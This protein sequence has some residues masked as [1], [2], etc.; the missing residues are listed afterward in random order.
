MRNGERVMKNMKYTMLF[1]IALVVMMFAAC[2]DIFDKPEVKAQIENGYGRISI[3][4]TGEFT[5]PGVERTI[6]PSTTFDKYEYTFTKTGTTN[7]ITKV[8][9]NGYFILEAGSYTVEVKASIL[10]GPAPTYT[11]VA[12]GKSAQFSVSSNTST[13][14]QVPLSSTSSG[15]GK[16][17][18]A[19]TYP[20]GATCNITLKKW[21]DNS[22]INLTLYNGSGNTQTLPL[23]LDTGS[24]LLTVIIIGT[25]GKRAGKT[26]AV[27]IY[28]SLE[29]KY[30][31]DFTNADLLVAIPPTVNAKTIE[32]QQGIWENGVI[33]ATTTEQW[34]KFTATA[35]TQYIHVSFGTVTNLTVQLYDAGGKTV[36]NS[37]NL[38]SGGT[39][40]ISSPVA[41]DQVYYIKV[42]SSGNNG[43]YWI[44][45]SQNSTAPTSNFELTENIWTDG[46][47][48]S[49]RGEQWFKLTAT[50]NSY[51]YVTFGTLDPSYGVNIQLY[52]LSG[53]TVGSQETLNNSKT[54]L[55]VTSSQTYYIR[56]WPYNSSYTG[57][58][59]ITFNM[60]G[61][62]PSPTLPSNISSATTLYNY[63]WKDSAVS[64]T[65]EQW[66]KF[67]ATSSSQYIHVTFG[68]LNPLNGL[69]VQVYNSSGGTVGS[70]TNLRSGGSKSTYLSSVTSGQPYYVLVWPYNSSDTGT[71]QIAFNDSTTSPFPPS[72]SITTELTDNKWANGNIITSGDEQWFKLYKNN[73]TQYIH[74]S[75]GTLSSSIGLNVQVYD[76]SGNTVISQTRLS[77]S[78]DTYVYMSSSN[79]YYYYIKVTPYNSSG[80]GTYKIAFNS[81]ETAPVVLPSNATTLTANTWADGTVYSTGEQWFKFTAPSYYTYI[82]ASF[83]T[84]SSSYG[85]YVEVYDSSGST[86]IDQTNFIYNSSDNGTYYIYTSSL[87]SGQVY[88]I[89]ITPNDYGYTGTYQIAFNTSGNPPLPSNA[90]QGTTLT[91]NTWTEGNITSSN[92][93][94]FKLTPTSNDTYVHVNFGSLNSSNGLYVQLY[95]S[96]GSTSGYNEIYNYQKYVGLSLTSGQTYYIKVTPRYSGS[97]GTYQ[98]TFNTSY[99]PP[100]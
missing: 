64:S 97:T 53:S 80:T 8:P 83:G 2:D 34:F 51:I 15:Q 54:S 33:S 65:G 84:L 7:P 85:M 93:E 75:F 21:S 92:G 95:S 72:E 42:S 74:A 47:I 44:A 77:S 57:T 37:A 87:T 12:S 59:Q 73:Y 18:C 5:T 48:S 23:S 4:L 50:S 49:L 66:F 19:I 30:E 38:S 9:D 1:G 96:T 58:Y 79:Y 89:R 78:G 36:G 60:S 45:F 70:R 24:Y 99:T 91:A 35:A 17:S 94:W 27:H 3:D 16:F 26:E 62:P 25:D 13:T 29:T 100:K 90:L 31:K 41:K 55:S 6:M 22:N 76:S 28:S 52:N 69:Y 61:T 43:A 88:Y 86:I 81:S 11:Q 98:I 14:V 39:K 46:G 82:Y 32:L 10:T 71:Y 20:Q 67:I 68:T 63:E 40:Y 56:V